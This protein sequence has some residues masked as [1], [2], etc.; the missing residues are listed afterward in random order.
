[1]HQSVAL[2]N[3]M[4]FLLLKV[5]RQMVVEEQGREPFLSEDFAG[6]LTTNF[7][8]QVMGGVSGVQFDAEVESPLGKGHVRFLVNEKYLRDPEIDIDRLPT[9]HFL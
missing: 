1:M 7:K 4:R 3:H 8:M 6:V 2:H 9:V 5:A